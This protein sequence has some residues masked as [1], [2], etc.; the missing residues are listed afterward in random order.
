V[1]AFGRSGFQVGAFCRS[2][3]HMT[4][5]PHKNI[6]LHATKYI[7]AQWYFVTLCC[8]SRR[9]IF[10]DPKHARWIIE[11]LRERSSNH[12]FLVHAYSAMPDHLH[13]L[14]L[15]ADQSSDLLRFVKNFKQRTA[16]DF[17]KQCGAD[18]WQKK[19]YDHI[20]REED[21]VEGVAGYIWFN[22]V[23]KG[24]VARPQDY[25]F[26]GSFAADWQPSTNLESN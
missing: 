19:F 1:G 6:R 21:S 10:A 13:V 25:P 24:L 3:L 17:R 8:A 11:T 22:P 4:D 7:G 9:Q 5:Y 16:Y 23:R 26:S 15:G 14:T 2:G 18:L 20:L 12:R